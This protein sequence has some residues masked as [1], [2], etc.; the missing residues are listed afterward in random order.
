[1]L[2]CFFFLRTTSLGSVGVVLKVGYNHQI[3]SLTRGLELI[4]TVFSKL[5]RNT[6]VFSIDEFQVLNFLPCVFI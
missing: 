3:G 1:M 5:I 6:S 2:S 4:G